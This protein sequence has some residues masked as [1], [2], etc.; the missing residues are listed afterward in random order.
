[1]KHL[2][3]NGLMINGLYLVSQEGYILF[4][5]RR[6]FHKIPLLNKPLIDCITC[7]SSI[8]GVLYFCCFIGLDWPLVCYH[9]KCLYRFGLPAQE[10]LVFAFRLALD[11]KVLGAYILS[12]A[13]V[14]MAIFHLYRTIQ[15]LPELV[16]S[17]INKNTIHVDHK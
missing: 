14:N 7:M 12:L 17:I 10:K 1:M 9:V 8:Y 5:L 15:N 13:I 16:V 11:F 6:F 3:V 4:F 2:I